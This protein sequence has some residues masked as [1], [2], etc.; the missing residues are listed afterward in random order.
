MKTT[1][2]GPLVPRS[3]QIQESEL[4]QLE[5]AWNN[6]HQGKGM[7]IIDSNADKAAWDKMLIQGMTSSET[8]RQTIIKIGNDPK[9][10]ITVDLGRNQPGVIVDNFGT[11]QVDLADIGK[12]P[13]VPRPG[14]SSEVTQSE[15]I[16]HFLEERHY[17]AVNNTEFKPAHQSGIDLQNTYRDEKGQSH[18][19]S[20]VFSPP[21]PDGS[22]DLNINFSNNTTEVL[23]IDAQGKI[24]NITLPNDPKQQKKQSGLLLESTPNNSDTVVQTSSGVNNN[25]GG[26]TPQPTNSD[27]AITYINAYNNAPT[28]SIPESIVYARDKTLTMHP[29]ISQEDLDTMGDTILQINQQELL[30]ANQPTQQEI[31]L[32]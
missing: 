7:N 8:F 16:L 29:N 12:F 28:D 21:N 14:H 19:T 24:T 18:V 17:A 1:I 15:V 13:K 22:V 25:R 10:T 31:E 6:I 27:P 32:A 9:N 20:Q 5:Q 30:A 2:K 4:K 26:I 23:H 11:N 3:N